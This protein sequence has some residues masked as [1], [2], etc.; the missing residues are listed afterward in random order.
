MFHESRA[1]R[2]AKTRCVV[3]RRVTGQ[4]ASLRDSRS[5]RGSAPTVR[6]VVYGK[7]VLKHHSLPYKPARITTYTVHVKLHR[8]RKS[9][10]ERDPFILFFASIAR[11]PSLA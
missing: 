3:V 9:E 1:V 11:E 6:R 4:S 7:Q 10:R 5:F 2:Q 8:E